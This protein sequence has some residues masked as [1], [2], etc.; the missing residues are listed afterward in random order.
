MVEFECCT[1]VRMR[2]ERGEISIFGIGDEWRY[3]V[4][5]ERVC[6]QCRYSMV[7]KNT[8]NDTYRLVVLTTEQ[9][10]SQN[11]WNLPVRI[12][13]GCEPFKSPFSPYSIPTV[14]VVEVRGAIL[15]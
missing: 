14:S 15:L 12:L 5:Y 11:V 10:R 8:Q 3:V 1:N 13:R 6:V 4:L 2:E 7:G 9:R